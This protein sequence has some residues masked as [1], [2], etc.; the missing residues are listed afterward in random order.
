S[1]ETKVAAAIAAGFMALTAGA[2]AQSQSSGQQPSQYAPPATTPSV[3]TQM[4]QR[5]S[6]DSS[7]ANQSGQ[8]TGDERAASNRTKRITKHRSK[9]V[10][11]HRPQR[12]QQ[13]QGTQTNEPGY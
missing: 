6:N 3:N 11:K 13:K 2:I 5:G 8:T 4:G 7:N 1:I 10:I 12:T 9:T